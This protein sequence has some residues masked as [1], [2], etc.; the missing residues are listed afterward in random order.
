LILRYRNSFRRRFSKV[1]RISF[2]VIAIALVTVFIGCGS[3][4]VRSGLR[5]S[6]DF[7]G[8]RVQWWDFGGEHFGPEIWQ[9][10]SEYLGDA[11]VD[12]TSTGTLPV[13]VNSAAIT[14]AGFS[15]VAQSLPVTLNPSQSVTL[16]VQFS[17]AATG[18]ATGQLTMSSNST[19]SPALVALSGTGTAAAHE[20]DL[21]WS[22]PTD[23]PD[24]C[25]GVQH[26]SGDRQRTFCS[27]KPF[28]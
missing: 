10:D 23:S 7:S 13:T 26:L 9:P 12:T 22:A 14:G 2:P 1:T 16:Q 6:P 28:A 3:G 27:D 17:P 24:P 21:S 11:I 18:V 19:G 4:V 15:I 25:V 8:E 5:C 20:V